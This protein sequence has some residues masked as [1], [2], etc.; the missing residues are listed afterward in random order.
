M[1]VSHGGPWHPQLGAWY[2]V[3]TR[4]TSRPGDT[5]GGHSSSMWRLPPELSE[6]QPLALRGVTKIRQHHLGSVARQL[7]DGIPAGGHATGGQ[8]GL[9]CREDVAR[10]VSDH[11]CAG[12]AQFARPPPRSAHDLRPRL[13]VAAGPPQPEISPPPGR[14][15]RNTHTTPP[16]PPRPGGAAPGGGGGACSRGR[17]P[18]TTGPRRRSR[19]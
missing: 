14:P 18:S 2:E 13:G 19:S 8:P 9:V 6:Q 11:Q 4:Y 3:Y 17:G 12:R 15:P 5:A 1:A 10:R 7:V 16:P